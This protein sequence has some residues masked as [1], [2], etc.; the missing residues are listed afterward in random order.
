MNAQLEDERTRFEALDPSCSFLVQAPAGSGKSE[1]LT[2][3]IIALLS[4]VR[5][6]EEIIAI[7]FTRKAAGELRARVLE[8][9]QLGLSPEPPDELTKKSWLLAKKALLHDSQRRWNILQHPARLLISTI[10]VFCA[11][12]IRAMP[13][14]SSI[15]GTPRLVENA[16]YYYEKAAQSTLKTASKYKCVATLFAYLDLDTKSFVKTI[17]SMLQ[18][19]DQW[20]SLLNNHFDRKTLQ[21]MLA[22]TVCKDLEQ[23][24]SIMP[25]G[26]HKLVCDPVRQA[27]AA[28]DEVDVNHRF[29]PLRDWQQELKAD[30]AHIA[31]W[32]ALAQLLLTKKGELRSP[33]SVN[34]NLGF[35]AG[36]KHKKDFV[37][38]IESINPS[39]LW[40]AR[41]FTLQ[42]LPT[43]FF[44]DQ[45]WKIFRTQLSTLSIA[46][47][48]LRA[49]FMEAM[50]VDFTEVAQRAVSALEEATNPTELLDKAGIRIKHLLVDEFQDTSQSQ[51]NLMSG[52]TSDWN[53]GDGRT[54]FFVGDPMQSI[55]RFRQADVR[56]FLKVRDF[57]LGNLRPIFLRLK[58][59]FRSQAGITNWVNQ[60]FNRL[61]P[62]EE[63][64]DTNSIPYSE[65][66]SFHPALEGHAV[67][68]HP[69]TVKHS[70]KTSESTGCT[71]EDIAVRLV[72][73][74]FSKSQSDGQQSVA[75]L[76]HAR[77]HLGN[78]LNRF[79]QEKI[80][81]RGTDLVLLEQRQVVSDLLQLIRALIHPGDRLAWLCVLRAPWCGLTLASLHALFGHDFITPIPVL[82]E[83]YLSSP[84][85][86]QDG[87]DRV[88]EAE[89][90]LSKE[91]YI[92][93]RHLCS[94]MLDFTNKDGTIPFAAWVE[95]IWQR[96]GGAALY[97][98]NSARSDAESFFLLIEQYAPYGGSGLERLDAALKC[99]FAKPNIAEDSKNIVDVM[100]I[101]KAKGLQFD[102][103]ILYGLHHPQKSNQSPLMRFEKV[104]KKFLVA[105][106]KMLGNEADPLLRYLTAR[107]ATQQAFEIDRLLYVAVTRA[108]LRLHLI[109]NIVFDTAANKPRAPNS[110]SMLARLWGD[111]DLQ[112]ICSN[113]SLSLEGE[114][115]ISSS[116][117]TPDPF[118]KRITLA[119]IN[120]LRSQETYL[121]SQKLNHAVQ[122][123][124][125]DKTR[126]GFW[127]MSSFDAAVGTLAHA[128]LARIGHDGLYNWPI[129]RLTKHLPSMEKQLLRAGLSIRRACV[130]SKIVLD[131]LLSALGDPIGI[132]LLSK[133]DARREWSLADSKG[134]VS[135]ID[136]ALRV[137]GGWLI[138]DYKTGTLPDSSKAENF[139]Q[140][141]RSHYSQQ[142]AKYCFLIKNLYGKP[143]RSAL[144][145]P[146]IPMWIE[147]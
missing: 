93:V 136:V 87:V 69:A 105:P 78:L 11:R 81:Y 101:H 1:L 35:P 38:W 37:R 71:A 116:N 3:R 65:S 46:A 139:G 97:S 73:E 16:H 92:R 12:L 143:V 64:I 51:I 117:R 124:A 6:P 26:W 109:G 128:W 83:R 23:V 98:S 138:V 88:C 18:C 70:D 121:L 57:G 25:S 17:T 2:D 40:I 60:Q 86:L 76:V 77:K 134:E 19:R 9:L 144:Y 67:L 111:R 114:K 119:G 13:Y 106:M 145:F 31:H 115:C 74:I 39:S 7:T 130:G 33:K 146:R 62:R 4:T 10:D 20:M 41:F 104:D 108:R 72:R 141:M 47:K 54:I 132:W 58:K 102:N 29:A 48:R 61:L 89:R 94:I 100:T 24:I 5:R 91:E 63:D 126:P 53:P 90:I 52:L 49:C 133:K 110:S 84:G 68:F 96:L 14:L 27:V 85:N 135:V 123:T 34:R 112:K 75:I 22:D 137:S 118:L 30:I 21:E 80:Q 79:S 142:L 55:Y 66:Y 125:S 82:L 140:H 103:V 28:L 36:S 32:K 122:T 44:S 43:P 15:G 56:L 147:C 127:P 8:K 131:I 99:S 107:E 50:Q 120:V 113:P 129:S 45:Q 59:N 95:S 42:N